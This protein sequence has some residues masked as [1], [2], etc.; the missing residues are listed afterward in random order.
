MFFQ[1]S[2][3]DVSFLMHDSVGWDFLSEDENTQNV[4]QC[5]SFTLYLIEW[6]WGVHVCAPVDV[7]MCMYAEAYLSDNPSNST[8]FL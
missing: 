3:P 8:H 2:Y 7:N 4:N 6:Y 5:F 1:N